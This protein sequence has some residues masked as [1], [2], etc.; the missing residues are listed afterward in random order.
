[1]TMH[2]MNNIKFI[3]GSVCCLS[4]RHCSRAFLKD[5]KTLRIKISL[6]PKYGN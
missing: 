6:F 3:D 2:G 4:A 5:M 1:M